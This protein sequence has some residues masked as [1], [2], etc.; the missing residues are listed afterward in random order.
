MCQ[1]ASVPGSEEP[2]LT[3]LAYRACFPQIEETSSI[4]QKQL[5]ERRRLSRDGALEL[6]NGEPP[7]E[8]DEPPDIPPSPVD[9]EISLCALK[10]ISKPTI[11]L[12]D[13]TIR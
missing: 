3:M 8:I 10:G 2:S 13:T 12:F 6:V 1:L 5:D 4:I 9:V 11:I 7:I